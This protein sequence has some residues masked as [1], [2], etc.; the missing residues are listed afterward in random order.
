[1]DELEETPT[2]LQV[3]D[4]PVRAISID[5]VETDIRR[6]KVVDLFVSGLNPKEILSRMIENG[7]K[8]PS[9]YNAEIVRRDLDTELM[10][11]RKQNAN[12]L[13]HSMNI[14]LMRLDKIFNVMYEMAIGGDVKAA[15]EAISI[16]DMRAKLLGLY[17]ISDVKPQDWREKV[18]Q[19]L[20]EGKISIE[21]L[22][23]ELGDELAGEIIIARGTR[24]SQGEQTGYIDGIVK[25]VA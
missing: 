2:S 17:R 11:V 23:K 16:I 3:L 9:N 10:R 24:A 12:T 13:V 8:I 22:K 1:M 20:N 7:D 4:Q 18:V 6:S 21:D 5:I 14:E 19:L 15:K 25:E